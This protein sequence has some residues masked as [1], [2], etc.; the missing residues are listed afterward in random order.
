MKNKIIEWLNKTGYPLELNAESVL[1]EKGF[2]VFNSHYYIDPEK[3]IAREID[4]LVEYSIEKKDIE[5]VYYFTTVHL[6]QVE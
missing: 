6:K 3:K 5:L 2:R 4:L 1:T